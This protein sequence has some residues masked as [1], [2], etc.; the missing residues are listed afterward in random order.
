VVGGKRHPDLLHDAG[1]HEQV[2]TWLTLETS[3]TTV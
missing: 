1:V 2:R 3:P